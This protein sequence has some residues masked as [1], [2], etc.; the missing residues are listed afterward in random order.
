MYL[1]FTVFHPM[2]FEDNM[3]QPLD[4]NGMVIFDFWDHRKYSTVISVLSYAAKTEFINNYSRQT[5]SK[6]Q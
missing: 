4:I 5:P 6:S 1:Q 3:F 2:K